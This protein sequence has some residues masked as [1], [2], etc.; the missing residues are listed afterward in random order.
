MVIAIVATLLI[1]VRR[2][3]LPSAVPREVPANEL[4]LRND[5]SHWKNET[6]PFTGIIVEKYPDGSVKSR[7]TLLNG[8]LHGVSEGWH[9]NGT[10]QVREHF[11]NG[12]SHGVRTKWFANGSK[13]SEATIEHGK[14]NGAFRRWHQNGALA[15]EIRMTS[16]VPD[17]L[18]RAYYPNGTLKAQAK[19]DKGEVVEQQFWK[20]GEASASR[21]AQ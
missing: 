7:S 17:G 5:R 13:M 1:L 2:P 21:T 11:Q 10:L 16:N 6:V 18:S 9:T 3:S 19:L 20:E 12:V 8:I 14:I 15:E 4:T